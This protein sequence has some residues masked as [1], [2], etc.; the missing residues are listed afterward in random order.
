MKK[1][2]MFLVVGIDI[3]SKG[4]FWCRVIKVDYIP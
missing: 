3:E 4:G 2:N 1:K